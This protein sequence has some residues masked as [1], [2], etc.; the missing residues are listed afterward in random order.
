MDATCVCYND[1]CEMLVTCASNTKVNSVACCTRNV[2]CQA[3]ETVKS[4]GCPD[5]WDQ[6]LC[7]EDN[8][9]VGDGGGTGLSGVGEGG[10]DGGC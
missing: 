4:I 2:L 7:W 8:A 9:E 3:P 5:Y 1:K 10:E 6:K